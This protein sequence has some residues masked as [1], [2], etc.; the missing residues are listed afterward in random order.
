VRRAPSA[1]RRR[2][3]SALP[4]DLALESRQDR[5]EAGVLDEVAERLQEARPAATWIARSFTFAPNDLSRSF[6]G[7]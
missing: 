1:T 6:S 7:R 3:R 4:P 2:G 5:V